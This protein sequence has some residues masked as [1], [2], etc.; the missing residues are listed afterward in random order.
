MAHKS[1][2]G[3]RREG[4]DGERVE[5]FAR[6]VGREYLFFSRA[7]RFDQ[8]QAQPNPPLEDWLVLLDAVQRRVVRRLLQPDDED[9]LRQRIRE[10]FPEVELPS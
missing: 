4:E 5:V 9:W 6:K 1:E 3:W 10:R 2:S 7:R 8:W